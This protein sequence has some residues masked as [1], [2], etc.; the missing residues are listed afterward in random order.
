VLQA[1]SQGA[2]TRG[3]TI[4]HDPTHPV[5]AQ[6]QTLFNGE[7][8]FHTLPAVAIPQANAQGYPSIPAHAET[9]QALL[10]IGTPIFAMPRG[11]S[12]RPVSLRCVLLDAI[13]GN[14]RRVLMQPGR[15]ERI[16]LQGFE[17]DGAKHFLEMGRKQRIEDVPHAVI[18][19]GSTR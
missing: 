16:D 2:A 14:R 9:Q 19:E 18:L 6:R 8:G 15:R 17:S 3:L 4:R 11:R 13:E 1:P 7:R 10:E 5:H 12:G